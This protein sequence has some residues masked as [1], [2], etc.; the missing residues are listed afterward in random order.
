MKNLNKRIV[1]K[2][3][4]KGRESSSVQY[5]G[6]HSLKVRSNDDVT[7]YCELGDISTLIIFPS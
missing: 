2:T 5:S 7:M 1:F 4:K 6:V 3:K